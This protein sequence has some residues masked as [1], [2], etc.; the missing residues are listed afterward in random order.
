MR[1]AGYSSVEVFFNGA[2]LAGDL[3][4]DGAGS[5]EFN[6]VDADGSSATAV[7]S[8]DTSVIISGTAIEHIPTGNTWSNTSALFPGASSGIGTTEPGPLLFIGVTFPGLSKCAV[9]YDQDPPGPP[10]DLS[11]FELAGDPAV[12]F[13]GIGSGQV[14][15]GGTVW[16]SITIGQPYTIAAGFYPGQPSQAG[17]VS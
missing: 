12:T 15:L 14:S 10:A 17:T 11:K 5:F 16:P 13:F 9:Q 8:T 4:F 7:Q 2:I 3:V 6:G 1:S